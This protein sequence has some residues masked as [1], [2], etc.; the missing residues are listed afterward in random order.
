METFE[1]DI[2]PEEENRGG[3]KDEREEMEESNVDLPTLPIILPRVRYHR[4][5]KK[6]WRHDEDED[7][8]LFRL[9]K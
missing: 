4:D 6:V 3:G 5:K 1:R 8:E 7:K 2:K 9:W